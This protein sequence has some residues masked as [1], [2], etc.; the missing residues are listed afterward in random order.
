MPTYNEAGSVAEKVANILDLDYPP[1]LLD[2]VFIDSA[3][4][5]GTY[6]A[7]HSELIRFEMHGIKAKAI[8]QME[9]Q[10]KGSAITMAVKHC[11]ADIII[12]TDANTALNRESVKA[13]ARHFDEPAIGAV[14]GRM[15]PVGPNGPM[16]RHPHWYSDHLMRMGESRIDSVDS[17]YGEIGAFR[18][19]LLR[20]DTSQIAEDFDLAVSIRRAG[21]RVIYEPE[22]IAFEPMPETTRGMM[23]QH[24]RWTLGLICCMWKHRGWL[25]RP[26]DCY[27]GLIIPSHRL[28]RVM[29]PFLVAG[30]LLSSVAIISQKYVI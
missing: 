9:R 4:K 14:T 3:S 11:R 26:L 8:M 13:M 30:V 12:V 15:V 7:I 29:V 24:R 18:R 28:L 19:D 25:S 21:F 1:E 17:I 16:M 10:G 6:T 5:D 20:P 22:A 2:V 27:R 23:V